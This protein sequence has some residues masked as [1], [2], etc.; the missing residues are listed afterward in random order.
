MRLCSWFFFTCDWFDFF[1]FLG[2][3]HQN[4]FWCQRIHRWSKHRNLYPHI[5]SVSAERW[6]FTCAPQRKHY[7]ESGFMLLALLFFTCFA[8]CWPEIDK[9]EKLHP[10]L[11]I[12][13]D[14]VGIF[15]LT[16]PFFSRLFQCSLQNQMNLP[17][18]LRP[19]MSFAGLILAAENRF[20]CCNAQPLG[21]SRFIWQLDSANMFTDQHHVSL[22]SAEARKQMFNTCLW[23]A[24]PTTSSCAPTLVFLLDWHATRSA[25]EVSSYSSS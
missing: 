22:I 24:A 12:I 2:Q 11:S 1:F 15:S 18:S 8:E 13:V 3:V 9:G 6:S 14:N 5:Y 16:R 20:A 25:G 17:G 19:Q 7:P 4:K 21:C 10:A 23:G